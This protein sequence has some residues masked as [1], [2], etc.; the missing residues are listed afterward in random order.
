MEEFPHSM[1]IC[2]HVLTLRRIFT[3]RYLRRVRV[4]LVWG[5]VF[6]LMEHSSERVKRVIW[7]SERPMCIILNPFIGERFPRIVIFPH[8]LVS[9]KFFYPCVTYESCVT[10]R[11][12][13]L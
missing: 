6:V 4:L 2:D 7:I 3:G 10:F 8:F 9:L 11:I 1:F 5:T 12:P 13:L